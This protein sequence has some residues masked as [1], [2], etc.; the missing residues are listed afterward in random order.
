MK[1][2]KPGASRIDITVVCLNGRRFQ[3]HLRTQPNVFMSPQ[4]VDQALLQEAS[5]V[6]EHFPGRQFRL[7]PLTG[8]RFNFVE[9]K[10]D[11]TAKTEIHGELQC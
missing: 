10:S 3:R 5:R 4:Q 8:G 9:M 1:M 11:L 6:D 2:K 7:V